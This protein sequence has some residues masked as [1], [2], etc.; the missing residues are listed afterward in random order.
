MLAPVLCAT[1]AQ[2]TVHFPCCSAPSTAGARAIAGKVQGRG[3]RGLGELVRLRHPA[4]HSGAHIRRQCCRS[5]LGLM[6][7]LPTATGLWA[8][9]CGPLGC[10]WCL[11]AQKVLKEPGSIWSFLS[12]LHSRDLTPFST[13][14]CYA[15]CFHLTLAKLF[16]ARCNK[17]PMYLKV[18]SGHGWGWAGLIALGRLSPLQTQCKHALGSARRAV[19]CLRVGSRSSWEMGPVGWKS[20]QAG[21]ETE[22]G[23]P[24]PG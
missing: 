2:A 4:S 3:R 6:L 9:S 8:W 17:R 15:Y 1:I 20:P 19:R 7:C 12:P 24:L 13:T 18:R 23:F 16:R 14:P 22:Q 21:E 5:C 10:T 11:L